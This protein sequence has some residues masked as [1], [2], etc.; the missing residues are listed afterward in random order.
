MSVMRIADLL[1]ENGW[2][3]LDGVCVRRRRDG[4]QPPLRSAPR[5]NSVRA[6]FQRR[7]VERPRAVR[8]AIAGPSIGFGRSVDV[9]GFSSPGYFTRA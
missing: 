4:S 9:H 6:G 5:L 8:D 7:N 2:F 3:K 1:H